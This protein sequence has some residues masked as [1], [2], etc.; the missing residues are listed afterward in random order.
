MDEF[1]SFL[2]DDNLWIIIDNDMFEGTIYQFRDCFF[3]NATPDLIFDWVREN[4][5]KCQITW[6]S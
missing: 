4:G 3:S 6:K 5:Y 1:A 2:I